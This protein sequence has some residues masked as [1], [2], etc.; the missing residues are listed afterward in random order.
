MID[1]R[2]LINFLPFYYKDKDTEKVNNK[3]ILE[4]FLEICG[5]YFTDNIKST[6]DNSLEILNIETTSQ[7]YLSWLWDLLGQIPFAR[8]PLVAPLNLTVEQQRYLIKYSNELLKIRGTKKF[9]EIMFKIYS[10]SYNNLNLISIESEDFGWEKDFKNNSD[11][12]RPYLDMLYFD[13][14]VAKFDE[15]YNIKQCINVTF[16]ITCN[17]V[18]ESLQ[19]AIKAFIDRF[20]PFNVNPI[21]IINGIDTSETYDL[22]L[23]I[24]EKGKWVVPKNYALELVNGQVVKARVYTV[25]SLGYKVDGV[26]F[27]S[28][29]NDGSYIERVS[30]YN[31][32]ISSVIDTDLQDVYEFTLGNKVKRLTVNGQEVKL[33]TYTLTIDKSEAQ[34]SPTLKS[35]EVVI[36]AYSTLDGESKPVQVVCEQ[37]GETKTTN[38]QDFTSKWSFTTPGTYTFVI[39]G[40]SANRVSLVIRNY[41]RNYQVQLAEAIWNEAKQAY[42]PSGNYTDNLSIVCTNPNT[43]RFIPKITSNDS[44]LTQ[45]E[46]DQLTCHIVGSLTPLYKNGSVQEVKGFGTWEFTP[47]IEAPGNGNAILNVTSDNVSFLLEKYVKEGKTETGDTIDENHTYVELSLRALA[48]TTAAQSI[49][50]KGTLAFTLKIP[51]ESSPAKI[52]YGISYNKDGVKVIWENQNTITLTVEKSGSYIIEI[53]QDTS[54]RYTWDVTQNKP[55]SSVL[56]GLVIEAADESDPAWTGSLTNHAIYQI[57][58]GVDPEAVFTIWGVFDDGEVNE[59]GKKVYVYDTITGEIEASDGEVYSTGE[60]YTITTPKTVVFT[61]V[62]EDGNEVTNEKGEVYRAT[63]EVRDFQTIVELRCAPSASVLGEDGRASTKL[64]ITSNRSTDKLQI[65]LE[66]TGDVYENGD[67]FSTNK[68]GTYTFTALVNGSEFKDSEDN[69]VQITFNVIDPNDIEVDQTLIAFDQYG[70][71]V[72]GSDIIQITAYEG[73]EWELVIQN[74]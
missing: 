39:S 2:H 50:D 65:K 64:Y 31:F 24:Y 48:Q 49:I 3:G 22:V 43:K 16:N 12:I 54:A 21:V 57:P 19:K 10:N 14:N 73:T 25:N 47:S 6:I 55:S 35:I 33:P 27:S 59:E 17:N 42:V 15:Y 69:L 63:L 62:D 46:I 61:L 37:T 56:V 44:S 32:Y 53:Q 36:T 7:E 66:S 8:K 70:N 67:T 40:N 30:T 71:V 1:I 51:G 45:A 29:I 58:Q 28:R 60:E 9:F 20:V 41:I 11:I 34:L 68:P 26:H 18:S 5:D 52:S 4:R 23:E 38:S 72:E 13:D 74:Q